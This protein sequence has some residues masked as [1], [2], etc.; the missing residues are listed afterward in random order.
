M[1]RR[2]FDQ[3]S[4]LCRHHWWGIGPG[5]AQPRRRVRWWN[6]RHPAAYA[7]PLAAGESPAA[8][9]DVLTDADRALET[10]MLG[11]RLRDGLPLAALSSAGRA[12]AAD[13][14]VRRLLDG[15]AHAAGVVRDLT[16]AAPTR[17]D[18]CQIGSTTYR[19]TAADLGRR[20]STACQTSPRSRSTS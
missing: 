13:A 11:V 1:V 17:S 12:R 16:D 20:V 7:A 6:V 2:A 18:R 10:V 19:T 5:R 4:S 14:V 15:D 9:R 8:G 3:Y